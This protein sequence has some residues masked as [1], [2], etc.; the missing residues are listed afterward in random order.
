MR[1]KLKQLLII[2]I[3]AVLAMIMTACNDNNTNAD[4]NSNTNQNETSTHTETDQNDSSQ[5]AN[6]DE[7]F[8]ENDAFRLFS[9]EPN[10]TVGESFTVTGQARVF[11]AT[12]Q[13]NI[14]DGHNILAEGTVMADEGAPEWGDFEIEI[15]LENVTSKH[16]TLRL[17]VYS[18]KDGSMT[19]E[20]VIPLQAED[21]L[22]EMPG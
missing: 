4:E 12:F 5:D 15:Q 16:L 13:Y 10:S 8:M 20:M 21:D 18:A 19:H 6:H 2:S 3:I 7:P 1:R 17:F 22:V 11:E 9:P 14:E